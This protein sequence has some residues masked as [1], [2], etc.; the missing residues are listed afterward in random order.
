M[1][2]TDLIKL[3][4]GSS[5]DRGST[6]TLPAT[7]TCKNKQS[8]E[9]TGGLRTAP[10]IPPSGNSKAAV[11]CYYLSVIFTTLGVLVVIHSA[12]YA[13]EPHKASVLGLGLCMFTTGIALIIITNVVTKKEHERIVTYLDR[14]VE[15]LRTTRSEPD[16]TFLVE[17]MH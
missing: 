2:I 11:L 9:C 16:S 1:K 17:D 10:P 8:G 5:S 14:K 13:K 7:C 15:E 12:F 4:K 6:S 3:W